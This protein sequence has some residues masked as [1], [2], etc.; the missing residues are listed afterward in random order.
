VA[1]RRAGGE[2]LEQLELF[3]VYRGPAI[4]AGRRSLAFRARFRS[5]DHTLSDTE[6][7]RLRQELIEAAAELGAEL[8]S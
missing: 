6:L 8:R 5:M 7:A 4:G 1:L 3:D 2:L